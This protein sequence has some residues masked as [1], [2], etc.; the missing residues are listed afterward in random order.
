MRIRGILLVTALLF[1]ASGAALWGQQGRVVYLLGSVQLHRAAGTTT[2]VIGSATEVGDIIETGSDGTAIIA[3]ADGAEVKLRENTSL[4]ID[5][6]GDDILVNL[7]SGGAF[8]QVSGRVQ[9]ES[10]FRMQARGTVAGVR[11][12]KFF[13]AYGRTIED[14]PDIWL[15][16]ADG[17]VNVAAG[18][19]SADVRAGEGINVLASARVTQPRFYPWTL[20]LNWNMDPEAGDVVDRTDL[21]Q[22]YSDLLD[23]DYD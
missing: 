17:L 6:L 12:T 8:A 13:M 9:R 22:A 20:E 1:G 18:G 3:L 15:C 2:A 16:V 5:S 23:Q 7:E 4:R 11:G 14:E 10:R 19:Q 21:E